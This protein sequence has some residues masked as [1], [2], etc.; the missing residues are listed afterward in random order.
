MSGLAL[1][2]LLEQRVKID[3]LL[4][5]SARDRNVLTIQSDLLGSYALG[6]RNLLAL[7]RDTPQYSTQF[8]T[9]ASEVDAIGLVNILNNLNRAL[10]VGGNPLGAQTAFLVGVSVNPYALNMEEELHRFQLKAEAGADF[11]VTQPIFQVE[12]LAEF[13]DRSRAFA[14]R[15]PVI[16]GIWPLTSFRNAEFMHNEMPGI[17]VPPAIMEL[18][19]QGGRGRAGTPRRVWKSRPGN[20]HGNS[21]AGARGCRF[22]GRP[23]STGTPWRLKSLRCWVRF[24][25]RQPRG[26]PTVI[27][28]LRE[29]ETPCLQARKLRSRSLSEKNLARLDAIVNELEDADLPLE[30]ALVLYEEA[31]ETSSESCHQQL[32]EAEGRVELSDEE[33][34]R[35]DGGGTLRRRR[36]GRIGVEPS[37]NSRQPPRHSRATPP[38][39]GGEPQKFP[40]SAEEGWR[41]ERRGGFRTTM[42]GNLLSPE[43]IRQHLEEGRIA[44]DAE[45]DRCL[46]AIEEFPPSIHTAMRYSVFAGG[47]RLRPT[48]CLE[49]GRLFGGEEQ[50]LLQLGSALELIHTYSLIHDDLPALDNDDLRRGKATSHVM[51]GEAT[52]IL[53]GDALLTLA[54]EVIAG[55][56][57]PSA[58]CN[59]R[60]IRELAHAIGTER[61]MV[62]GQVID[63]ETTTARPTAATLDYI[64][65]AK[66]GAFIRATV[67]SGALY[68]GA[69]EEDLGRVSIYGEKIGLAFQIA[70]DLLDVLGSEAELGKTIGKDEQ[71]HKATYP[72]LHGVE[73]SQRIASQLI[74]EAC[75]ALE[76]YGV[77]AQVLQGIAKYIVGRR[78]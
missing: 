72:A 47:K 26:P 21:L 70:D 6:L 59:V 45:L 71:Q 76:V 9:A 20:A 17:T 51:F 27:E 12:H 66:T 60:V 15:L 32:E 37:V 62:G 52:A 25:A 49:A 78:Q 5:Y 73:A 11:A 67:R 29:R 44:V 35:E 69:S 8:Q 41:A 74:E 31:H 1:A 18:H 7:T 43:T 42:T 36:A 77:R 4:H 22:A 23:G 46:P 57:A 2:S 75:V 28:F 50:G 48:L 63:L 39:S 10:D 40:S 64:H 56:R 19:A 65:S 58:E 14:A 16:A 24:T 61:G 30:K 54:F 34:G 53:A 38:E 13:V 3:V 33:G 68:A 55:A